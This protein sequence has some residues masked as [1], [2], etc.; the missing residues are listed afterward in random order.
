MRWVSFSAADGIER[1]GVV[2]GDKIL[3]DEVGS[4]LLGLIRSE[5]GLDAAA[6]RIG[7]SPTETLDLSVV[8]LLPPIPE[9][10]AVRDFVSFELHAVNA[11]KAVHNSVPHPVWYKHPLFYFSNPA[12]LLGPYDEVPIAR[13]S[14]KFD[15]EV[16]VAAVIA[17]DCSDLTADTAEDYIAGYTIFCDWSAR[18][19]LADELQ[20]V[21]G[22]AKGKDS[23]TSMG[24]FLVT[25]DEL[26]PFRSGKGYALEMAGYVNGKRYGGG[27]W[28]SIH[29]SF[30]E[31]LEYASRGTTMRAGD[32]V[33]SG[34][35]GTGC[36]MEF[37]GGLPWL[38][39]GDTV[40]I[41]VQELGKI[42]AKILD[43]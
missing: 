21:L 26:E 39:A 42:E 40:T 25:P 12:T 14:E 8:R 19:F 35:V 24:P 7:A 20:F 16:E 30:G 17:R 43:F 37:A 15:Y 5:G 29:Y 23:A 32:I 28:D 3:A 36:I 34:T 31:M 38:K 27:S 22:P 18:D 11:G 4:T 1:C 41:E 10:P 2:Q 9:P 13:G 33:G 6:Q